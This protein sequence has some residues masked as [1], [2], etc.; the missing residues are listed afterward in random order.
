MRPSTPA[1]LAALVLA[2]APAS[3][4][5][6]PPAKAELVQL[7]VVVTDAQ[8]KP[9]RDLTR[10]DFEVLEDGRPQRL[11]QFVV[12]MR[13]AAAGPAGVM[14]GPGG[15]ASSPGGDPGRHILIVVDDLHLAHDALERTK[16]ALRRLVDE[17]VG[18]ED[19]V[20]VLATGASRVVQQFT[21]DRAV[22][23][24]AI[25]RLTARPARVASA[26]GSQMT[27]AEAELILRGD[28]GALQ[29]AARRLIAEPGSVLSGADSGARERWAEREVERQARA[30]LAEALRFSVGTLR[31]V[32]DAVR[33]LAS[34]PGRK[35]CLLASEGFLVG[36]GTGEERRHD[37]ERVIDAATRSGA[38]VYALDGRGLVTAATDASA[39]ALDVP[40]GL[41]A[42]VERQ[43]EQLL[44]ATLDTVASDTGGFVARGSNDLVAGLR[45]MLDDNDAYYLM[46]YE[47]TSTKRDGRFRR[48]EVRLPRRR[49]LTVRTRRG[50]F[51]PDD[52]L[53]TDGSGRAAPRVRPQPPSEASAWAVLGMPLPNDGVAVRLTAD[54][55]Q[56]PATG[57]QAVVRAHVDAAGLPW[58]EA[59]GRRQRAAVELVGGVY[60]VDGNPV[61]APF[62]RRAD[63]D[64]GAVE[65]RRTSESG[66]RY[67]Q[68]LP[69]APG[70]YQV[71]LIVREPGLAPLGGAVQWLDVPDLADK[72]LAMSG[73][74]LSS[75]VPAG[76]MTGEAETIRDAHTRRRFERGEGLY[77]QFYVYN[78]L[79]GETG[80][81]DVVLQAQIWAAG[82]VV[83]ASKPRPAALQVKDGVPLPETNGIS[84]EGVPPGRYELRIVVVDRNAGATIMRSVDFAVD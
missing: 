16:D 81:T 72:K 51:A 32:E 20:A 19:R 83:A 12:V 45:R 79:A 62:T 42:R 31:V 23:R 61:G 46:A 10:E 40:P 37:L 78:P 38:V 11:A 48:I 36:T 80:A 24:Q 4:Q 60:D 53:R 68:V 69:L 67:Q 63:L 56:L 7:D 2:G 34:L 30:L 54:Y 22:V 64:L 8:G 59:E 82:K 41:P 13:N 73:V 17:H 84:L 74:F 29:L 25:L 6:L 52:R 44:R 71:R 27:P 66:L 35:L 43:G 47:P 14:Y 3:P 9:V 5:Q 76:A 21:R 57:P 50:Y 26:R 18:A 75:S 28:Q 55:L 58:R 1:A 70:R 39:A 65:H 49:G 33:G 15:P 77:F